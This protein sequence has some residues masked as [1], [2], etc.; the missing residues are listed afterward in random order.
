VKVFVCG[1]TQNQLNN[2]AGLVKSSQDYVDGFIF[3]DGLS[4]DGTF[5]FLEANKKEGKIIQR[6][7]SNDHDLQM[8]LFLRS[9][10][11]KNGDWFFVRDSTERI[12]ENF[13]KNIKLSIKDFELQGITSLYIH[14]K[15]FLCKYSDYLYFNG[16]PHWGLHG[17]QG[18][19]ISLDAEDSLYKNKLDL[20]ESDVRQNRGE[21]WQINQNIKYY[22]C[23]GRSNNQLMHYYDNGKTPELYK[24][25]E[26]DRINFRN[27]CFNLG[28]EFSL[29]SLKQF[30]EQ[31][32]I[33]NNDLL[34]FFKNEILL[35]NWYRFNILNHSEAEIN[36]SNFFNTE[37]ARWETNWEFQVIK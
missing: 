23:Y 12:S 24:Q 10:V 33:L 16:S 11:M 18:R 4:T 30:I 27:I 3:V 35:K 9:N 28:I 19:S 34:P 21:G 7:W 8:N 2:I 22:F 15:I 29:S 31:N 20:F 26:G 13:L 14:N 25:K 37:K 36:D 1:I 6:E 32:G 5:E 17:I